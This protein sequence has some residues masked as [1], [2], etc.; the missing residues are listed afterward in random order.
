[1]SNENDWFFEKDHPDHPFKDRVDRLRDGEQPEKP[2]NPWRFVIAFWVV[3]V[4][5]AALAV[6]L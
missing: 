1:M 5:A 2:H 6:L 3:L 4:I